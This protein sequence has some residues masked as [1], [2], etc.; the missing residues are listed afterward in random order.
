M[1]AEGGDEGVVAE[2]TATAGDNHKV[3]DGE[4]FEGFGIGE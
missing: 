3:A 4:L 2:V 1:V